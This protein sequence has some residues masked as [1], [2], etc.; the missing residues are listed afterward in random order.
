MICLKLDRIWIRVVFLVGSGYFVLILPD[1]Q[2]WLQLL[3]LPSNLSFFSFFQLCIFL[4][5][6]ILSKTNIN[7]PQLAE[8]KHLM[9]IVFFKGE[10]PILFLFRFFKTMKCC[11]FSAFCKGSIFFYMF[12]IRS[13]SL[14][15]R[16]VDPATKI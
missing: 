15:G 14:I 16:V 12:Y 3:L 8:A 5:F 10:S 9:E 4:S 6:E 13:F 11:R 7:C 2:P 1:P